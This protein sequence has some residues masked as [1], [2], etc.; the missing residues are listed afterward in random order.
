MRGREIA[1][2]DARIYAARIL[3]DILYHH[4]RLDEAIDRHDINEH[5]LVRAI[6]A[7]TLRRLGEIDA[8]LFR[9]IEDEKPLADSYALM[10]LRSALAQLLYMRIPA[11]AA[12][13]L[14]VSAAK[15]HAKARHFAPLINA[16]LRRIWR[17]I[18]RGKNKSKQSKHGRTRHGA[19]SRHGYGKDGCANMAAPRQMPSPRRI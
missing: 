6:A 2:L 16:V 14:A 19:I 15:Q 4:R 1:G 8:I 3:Y 11:Y 18:W 7:Q 17:G 9:Y 13:D 10:L 5:A 12:I